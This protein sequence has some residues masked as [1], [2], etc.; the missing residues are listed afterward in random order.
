M[1][2]LAHLSAESLQNAVGVAELLLQERPHSLAAHLNGVR[3]N[4]IGST[5]AR[6]HGRQGAIVQG[7][8]S[9]QSS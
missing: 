8:V 7:E 6:G 9:N 5:H 4:R 2:S 1:T 3:Q